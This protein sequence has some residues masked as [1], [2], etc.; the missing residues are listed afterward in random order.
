[1]LS[2]VINRFKVYGPSKRTMAKNQRLYSKAK[3][4]TRQIRSATTRCQ[5]YTTRYSL[6]ITHWSALGRLTGEI[7]TE[8]HMPQ[9]FPGMDRIRCLR[10]DSNGL[11]KGSE[12]TWRHR[13]ERGLYRWNICSSKKRGDGV[14]KTKRGKGTK[15]MG[16]ADASGLPI[17][18]DTTSAS[19]HEITLVD[20]TLDSCFLENVPDKLIGDRAYDS[21]KLDQRLG[22][23]RGVELIAPHK[24][25]RVKPATQ[26]GR[27]LRRYRKRW[28]IERMFAWLQNFRR[29]VVRYE[30]HLKNFLAM[31]QLGCIVILLRRALG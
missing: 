3:S 12:G 29:L 15:I 26:D 6:D 19:P 22:I 23:E 4:Q 16:L 25:N 24:N 5:S 27:G 31:I 14:G 11:S 10:Q 9:A 2:C 21:D 28:K 30:Y 18:V 1:M 7:S 13:L 8:K 17:A 20:R